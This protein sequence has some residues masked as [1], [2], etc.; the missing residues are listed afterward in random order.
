MP[1]SDNLK[2]KGFESRTTSELRRISQKGGQKSGE[3]RRKKTKLKKTLNAILQGEVY[4]EELAPFLESVGLDN[5][6][7]SALCAALIARGIKT[8]DPKCFEVIAKYAGQ[9][10]KSDLDLE[11]QQAKV[12]LTK[13]K[14]KAEKRAAEKA[15]REEEDKGVEV[16]LTITEEWQE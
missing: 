1:N 2:G 15:S 14:V 10:A 4:V 9:T 13:E 16:E 8:G 6:A 3:A 7:E 11:G 12:D 5:T